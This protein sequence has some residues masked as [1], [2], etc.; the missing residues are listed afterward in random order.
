MV[1]A[2]H[3]LT[4]PIDDSITLRAKLAVHNHVLICD[5]QGPEILQHSCTFRVLA[6]F[7]DGI[8]GLRCLPLVRSVGR[9]T[10]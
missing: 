4:G 7:T 1:V 2:F 6:A 9:Y 3:N 5:F 10:S 8:W